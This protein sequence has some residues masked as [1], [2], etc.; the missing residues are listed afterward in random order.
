[1]PA[2]KGGKGETGR[3]TTKRPSKPKVKS[4]SFL[5][6]ALENNSVSVA[7]DFNNWDPQANPLKRGKGGVWKTKLRLL[8]GSYQYRLVIDGWDWREDPL[9]PNKVP[10]DF[11]TLNSLLKVEQ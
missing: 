2:K 6:T 10:N 3:A 5:F 9:N 1:M 11:G 4:V 7:G 8:P